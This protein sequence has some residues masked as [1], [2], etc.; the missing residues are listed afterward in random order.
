MRRKELARSPFP[1]SISESWAGFRAAS[2][3]E[4][5]RKAALGPAQPIELLVLPMLRF[6]WVSR[7]ACQRSHITFSSSQRVLLLCSREAQSVMWNNELK[8]VFTW[9]KKLKKKQQSIFVSYTRFV[10]NLS[11]LHAE[12]SEIYL[13]ELWKTKTRWTTVSIGRGTPF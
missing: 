8:Y 3:G 1:S 11:A 9:K 10:Q 13:V 12:S 2:G 6:Y 4:W 5:L 7:R